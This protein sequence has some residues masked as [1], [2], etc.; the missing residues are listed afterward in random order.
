MIEGRLNCFSTSGVG[1]NAGYISAM[2]NQSGFKSFSLAVGSC[3]G[4]FKGWGLGHVAIIPKM[5]AAMLVGV[6]NGGW[7]E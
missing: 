3:N 5:H 4:F 1:I 6:H 2:S 7:G